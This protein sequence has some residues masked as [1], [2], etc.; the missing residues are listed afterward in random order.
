MNSSASGT[1]ASVRVHSAAPH[2]VIAMAISGEYD[3]RSTL[4]RA[5]PF[6][7]ITSAVASVGHVNGPFGLLSL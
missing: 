3:Q 4:L 5:R 1:I 7:L 6:D 2:P